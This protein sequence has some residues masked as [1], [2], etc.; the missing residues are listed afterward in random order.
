MD[1]RARFFVRVPLLAAATAL[2]I[3]V[4]SQR[5]FAQAREMTVAADTQHVTIKVAG[6]YC[7]SCEATVHTML[8]RTRGVYSAAVDVKRG[9]AVIA[10]DPNRTTPQTLADVINRLGYKATLPPADKAKAGH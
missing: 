8:K 10:Y 9:L 6:M 5:A 1:L 7:A 3:G 4:G 2:C